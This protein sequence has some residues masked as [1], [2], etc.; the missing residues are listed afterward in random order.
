MS[1]EKRKQTKLLKIIIS[2]KNLCVLKHPMIWEKKLNSQTAAASRRKGNNLTKNSKNKF[3]QSYKYHFLWRRTLKPWSFYIISG[4]KHF[5]LCFSDLFWPDWQFQVFSGIFLLV[6]Q[7]FLEQERTQKKDF[8]LVR[9]LS[10][11]PSFR[12]VKSFC[13]VPFVLR[14]WWFWTLGVELCFFS[15]LTKQS[16]GNSNFLWN[17]LGEHFREENRLGCN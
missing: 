10:S 16:E 6:N 13:A 8:Q 1:E 14:S 3:P 15:F 5:Q 7:L 11:S 2:W 12:V 17:D 4:K 9:F